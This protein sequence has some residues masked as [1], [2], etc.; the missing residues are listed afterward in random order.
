[1]H[2]RREEEDKEEEPREKNN[3]YWCMK[4][5][6]QWMNLDLPEEITL[7]VDTR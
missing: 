6:K 2:S 1:M 3:Y 4:L 7:P 5:S